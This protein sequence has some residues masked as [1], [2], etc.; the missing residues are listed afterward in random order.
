M[1]SSKLIEEISARMRDVITNNPMQDVEKNMKI[2]L[3][4]VFSKLDLVSRE[5]FDIQKE[6][7]IKTRE[8][9]SELENRLTEIEK[10]LNPTPATE[11]TA[12]VIETPTETVAE[13]TV[14]QPKTEITEEPSGD[15]LNDLHSAVADAPKDETPL[16][17]VAK[18]PRG[19]AK[20]EQSS[21]S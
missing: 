17:E 11:T 10:A 20:K 18:K 8:K 16:V 3:Q 6:V 21:E 9:L 19:R 4:G 15:L 2:M 7:L 14:E 1:F 12:E 5:E 13:K